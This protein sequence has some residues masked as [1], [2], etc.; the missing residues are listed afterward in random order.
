MDDEDDR[1]DFALLAQHHEGFRQYTTPTEG[2]KVRVN[3]NDPQ[4]IKALTAA[5]LSYKYRI[6]WDIPDGCLCPPVP[7]RATYLRW[8]DRLLRSTVGEPPESGFRGID[9]GTGASC[10]YPLLGTTLFGFRFLATDT[11]EDSLLWAGRN[12]AS[13]GWEDKIHTRLQKDSAAVLK[14]V[15]DPQ[16]RYDFVVCNPPF[17]D[18]VE[19]TSSSTCNDV[20]TSDDDASPRMGGH[21][22]ANPCQPRRDRA[23]VMRAGEHS[24]EGGEVSFIGRMI[25]ESLALREQVVWYSTMLG[26]KRSLSILR[27]RLGQER[28][29]SLRCTTISHG[30]TTRWLLGWTFCKFGAAVMGATADLPAPPAKRPP[31]ATSLPPAKRQQVEATVLDPDKKGICCVK[32]QLC[33]GTST[34]SLLSSLQEALQSVGAMQVKVSSGALTASLPPALLSTGGSSPTPALPCGVPSFQLSVRLLRPP[35]ESEAALGFALHLPGSG[36]PMPAPPTPFRAFIA[37][38]VRDW[39]GGPRSG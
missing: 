29:L 36:K 33:P 11:D 28:G 7:N 8:M 23:T 10:I 25:D 17:F 20:D 19:N 13:N 9:I 32:C 14:G 21:G 30:R 12:I 15:V 37:A 2:G 18:L 22:G 6:Q 5:T 24:T 26:C 39:C 35:T 4:A 31:D 1:V 38:V 3:W 27:R 34:Q 16:E